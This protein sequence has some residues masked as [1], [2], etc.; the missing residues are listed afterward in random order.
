MA[1][2]NFVSKAFSYQHMRL[3]HDQTKIPPGQIRVRM[4]IV[5]SLIFVADTK[6]IFFHNFA[7]LL[8]FMQ[9]ASLKIL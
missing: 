9:I 6:I 1:V 8:M 2:P 3:G 5:L 7:A 4:L